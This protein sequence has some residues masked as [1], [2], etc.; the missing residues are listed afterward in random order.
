M[1]ADHVC[2]PRAQHQSPNAP[3][4]AAEAT[5]ELSITRG[6]G[7]G[8]ARTVP[9]VS[10]PSRRCAGPRK[11]PAAAPTAGAMRCIGP[12]T[13]SAPC[14][15][16]CS[17]L[18]TVTAER[19]TVAVHYEVLSPHG[20]DRCAWIWPRTAGSSPPCPSV[21]ACPACAGPR[22]DLDTRSARSG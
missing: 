13:G 18:T 2:R 3:A 6:L 7:L 5:D 10:E 12:W 8:P 14:S 20:F 17:P 1:K 21:R 11:P 9:P 19:R 4:L 16:L 22:Y 15:G